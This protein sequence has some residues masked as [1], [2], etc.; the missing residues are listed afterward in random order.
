MKLHSFCTAL[1][2]AACSTLGVTTASWAQTPVDPHAVDTVQPG[3]FPAVGK[4]Y[5]VDFGVQ[6]FRLDFTSA[7]EMKFTSPDG[8]NT[9]VVPITVTRISPTVFMVYWSRRAGQHVVHVEDFG[10]NLVYS[11]IFLPDGSAQRL[12][13]TLVPVQ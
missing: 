13:G 2:L 10:N 12:K 7:S 4:S 1:M 9:Q 6:K 8:K 11:N 3:D 5:D